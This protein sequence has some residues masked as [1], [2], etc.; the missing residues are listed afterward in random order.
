[1]A[2]RY[3]QHS[4]GGVAGWSK[5]ACAVWLFARMATH[6]CLTGRICPGVDSKSAAVYGRRSQSAAVHQWTREYMEGYILCRIGAPRPH[7]SDWWAPT[8][9]QH[10]VGALVKWMGSGARQRGDLEGLVILFHFIL[11]SLY[12]SST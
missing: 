10:L 2:Q 11:G 6:G 12:S 5:L 9:R 1:M 8:S 3:S 7:E 4:G